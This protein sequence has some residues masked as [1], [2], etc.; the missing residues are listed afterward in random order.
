MKVAYIAGPFRSKTPWGVE[1]NIRMAEMVAASYWRKGFAVITPHANS[2]FFTGIVPDETFLE[3]DLEILKRCDLL[4]LA[5]GWEQSEGA[6]AERELAL[7]LRIPIEEA[8]I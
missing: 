2:R 5:P 8:R 3:G 4:V 1:L 7:A 6:K